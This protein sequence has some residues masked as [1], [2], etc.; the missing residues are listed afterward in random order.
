MRIRLLPFALS[1]SK[2]EGGKRSCFDRLSMNGLIHF[3]RILLVP[4]A[5]F[6]LASCSPSYPKGEVADSLVK[7]CREEYGIEVKAQRVETTLGVEV[8]IPDLI[9]ELMKQSASAQGN[10]TPPILA[11]GQYNQDEFHFQFLAHGP[12]VRV[13]EEEEERRSPER[14]RSRAL[15]LLD[16]VSTALRRVA[17]STDAPL[18]FYMLIARD[19]GPANLDVLF[20]GHLSDLKRVQYY[21]ISLGELQKRS[22]FSVR[23]QPEPLARVMVARFLEDLVKQPPVPQ[24]LNR[25]VAP[26]RRLGELFPKVL[27]LSLEIQGQGK[28]LLSSKWPVR[29]ILR[30]QVL[31]YVPL[32]PID[33]PGGV[34][35]TV[36][37]LQD[38][39]G[40]LDLQRVEDSSLPSQYQSVGPPD[41]WEKEF[42]L[43]PIHL[44]QFLT[45]QI[46]KRVLSEFQP[47]AEEAD[48]KP[49]TKAGS[50]EPPKLGRHN[51]EKP[52][53]PAKPATREEVTEAFVKTSAYILSSYQF[54]DF[55]KITVTDALNGTHWEIPAKDLPLYRRRNAPELKP[56]P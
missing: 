38:K 33:R 17:L 22:R 20:S 24:F 25:Y 47:L 40:I 31:V 56:L 29:Q 28:A 2:G 19:P 52:K 13:E 1:L 16:Q 41:Q 48:S 55:D 42:Y 30:D 32:V 37:M 4:L 12:F 34:L 54:K 21:D 46:T 36:Q 51:K 15:T 11:D 9:N 50:K 5:A 53:P 8:V 45:E 6:F 27:A 26:S 3:A 44:T 23:Q 10:L 49:E 14:E 39:V 35:F 18:E 7:L 43:E